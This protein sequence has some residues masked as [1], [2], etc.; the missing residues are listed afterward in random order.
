MREVSS[1]SSC[2]SPDP[3]GPR[4]ELETTFPRTGLYRLWV[5]LRR[6]DRVI[7]IPFVVRVT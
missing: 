6:W 7:T 2:G 5:K 4:L 1:S 3:S